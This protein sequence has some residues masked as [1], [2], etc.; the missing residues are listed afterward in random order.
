MKLV[1]TWTQPININTGVQQGCHLSPS[2]FN[3]SI[4]QIIT[5]WN[6]E[7]MKGIKISRKKER[8][9]NLHLQMAKL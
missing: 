2:L 9:K 8:T 1:V 6:E 4:N 7:E 5:E 3:V